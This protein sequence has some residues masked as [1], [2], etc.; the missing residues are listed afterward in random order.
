[1]GLRAPGTGTVMSIL[2][3]WACALLVN[4]SALIRK[5]P[6]A[7]RVPDDG[8]VACR[9][10]WLIGCNPHR[11]NTAAYGE[12]KRTWQEADRRYQE[13]QQA[14]IGTASHPIFGKRKG[15]SR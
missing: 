5:K 12:W 10:G 2:S 3:Q 11:K 14:L 8:D 15:I 9:T 1:M 7:P 6:V 4:G 13:R